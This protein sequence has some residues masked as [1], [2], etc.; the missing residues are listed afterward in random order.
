MIHLTKL[1]SFIFCVTVVGRVHRL[2]PKISTPRNEKEHGKLPQGTCDI[3]IASETAKDLGTRHR[4]KHD[5]FIDVL[6]TVDVGS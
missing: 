1:S 5:H 4:M 2:R 3:A 6:P